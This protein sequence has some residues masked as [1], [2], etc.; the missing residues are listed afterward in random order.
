MMCAWA[1]V[2]G[3]CKS[4][5]N[6]T[7]GSASK[8]TLSRAVAANPQCD[9][10]NGGITLPAGFCA[11]IFA[12]SVGGAR[13]ITVAPDG[14][15]YVA[16]LVGPKTGAVPDTTGPGILVLSDANHDGHADQRATFGKVGGTGI[17]VHNG[18]LYVDQVDAIVR[19]TLPTVGL[20]PQGNVDTIV[21]NLPTGGHGARNITFT[22]DGALLVNI[23]SKTNSCQKE[24]RAAHSPGIDP[25]T[26]LATRAG[27]W[28]FDATRKYQTQATAKQF[29]TGIRNGM[30]LALNPVD[31][32]IWGTQHGRDQLSQNWPELYDAHAGAELPA[33]ELVQ[34]NQGDDFGWPYCYY[35][36]T[37]K[38]LILAPEYGGDRQKTERCEQKKLPVVTFPGHW[39]P[40][41]L[42]FY[43]GTMFPEHY[44]NG[45]FIAFHGS[46]NRSP[47]P[48]D[49]YRVVFVPFTGGNPTVTY[50]D[51]AT[52]FAG[53]GAVPDPGKARHRP[54]GIAVAPDGALYITDD[55]GGR[56]WRVIKY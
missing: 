14:K 22:S 40:M 3:A 55:Q 49:G 43:T 18:G 21:R 20:V 15:V 39:A 6:Q 7:A 54:V 19:Y 16:L 9:A 45:A 28:R 30:G 10:G 47:E 37:Q 1:L 26:E 11:S 27:T 25:C 33:E 50:E 46:W 51:F 12:D 4:R 34:E 41:S 29:V 42:T 31:S 17:A 35:D 36:P 38:K 48:Q 32:K 52:G 13:H 5:D 56:I 24:D 8:D 2:L 53:I 23:G 44:R